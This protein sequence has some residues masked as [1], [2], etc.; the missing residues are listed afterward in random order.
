MDSSWMQKNRLTD[1]YRNGVSEFLKFAETKLPNS[2]G[3]FYCPCVKCGNQ[4]PLKVKDTREHLDVYGIIQS[5]T[6]WTWHCE[7]LDKPSVSK[8]RE[9]ELD[10]GDR[11]EDMIRDIGPDSFKRA[12]Y[13]TL[14][15]DKD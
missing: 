9:V 4:A 7:V 6:T 11:L 3:V 8:S 1:E 5:Y 13:D 14:C 15:S 10:M 12:V 2:N